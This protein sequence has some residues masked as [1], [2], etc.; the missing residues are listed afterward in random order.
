[1]SEVRTVAVLGAGT[2][3]TG[4]AQVCAFHG[5]DVHLHDIS[6]EILDRSLRAIGKSLG[7]FVDKGKIDEAKK[8]ATVGRIKTFTDITAGMSS[9]DLVIEALT[10]NIDVKTDSYRKFENQLGANVI[11]GSN[12]SSLPITALASATNR[13]D[14]FIGI[15]FMNPV[16]LM[17]GVE[18]IR[19]RES[20]DETIQKVRSFLGSIDKIPSV[21]VDYA[22]FI[23]SRLLNVY[24]NE[25]ALAVM[26][27]NSPEEIDRAMMTCT[28]MPMGPCKLLDLVGID[29]AV[30]VLKI[31]EEEFGERFKCAPLLKQMVRAGHFGV[32]SGKGFY[33]YPQ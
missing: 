16:P 14:R 29:V 7:K 5:Y 22:G 3:G 26:D 23:T 32:K 19:G 6:K 11:I 4:I 1:M 33:D 20:S 13:K 28:N 27:G 25:A 8:Q 12:T 9:V 18:I 15:H 10:E 30:Y 21:A 2:M 17:K 24:L 31:L